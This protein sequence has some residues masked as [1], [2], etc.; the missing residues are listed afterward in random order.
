[1]AI[2]NESILSV[3]GSVS[4]RERKDRARRSQLARR[5]AMD[6]DAR[7][8]A[9][10]DAIKW[11]LTGLGVCLHHQLGLTR[12]YT[13]RETDQPI[14]VGLYW[15]IRSEADCLELARP[16]RRAGCALALPF[17]TDKAK[18]VMEFR[19]WQDDV[20]LVDA[21]FGTKAPGEAADVVAPHILLVPLVAFDTECQR[22]GYGAGFYDRYLGRLAREGRRPLLA[23]FG[24]GLQQL[25]KVPTEPYD[26]VLDI[27]ITDRG[28]LR[29][30]HS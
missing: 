4:L 12:N 24:F 7:I 8:S 9:T 28:L 16:L 27:I 19:L 6:E 2:A 13:E 10:Q 14:C 15:P 21:G 25:D 30:P 20:S 26:Q 23:G 11:A 1:M 17:I 5:D 3:S 29:A 18:A 22:L